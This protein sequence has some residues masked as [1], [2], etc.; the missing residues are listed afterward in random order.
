MILIRPLTLHFGRFRANI[1]WDHMLT[2]TYFKFL[3]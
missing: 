3:W 1:T 2:V